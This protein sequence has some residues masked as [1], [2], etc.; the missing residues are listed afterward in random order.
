MVTDGRHDLDFDW[1]IVG[2]GFGGSIAA[3][4]L[5][6]RG[7]SVCV[8]ECG[9]RFADDELPES[10]WQLKDYFWSPRL[11]MRGILRMTLFRDVAIISG[12]GVGGGSLVYAQTLYRGTDGFREH[13]DAAVGEPVD[14]DRYYDVAERML[15]V[16]E[17]PLTTSRDH[18]LKQAAERIGYDFHPTRVGVYR[19]EPG[20]TVPDPYFGG[21]GPDRAG[22]IDCG[23]CIVSCVRRTR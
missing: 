6:E 23:R 2:S 8:L 10:A 11:G 15:G 7:Y 1:V 14:L 17:Q 18:M 3:L 12:A 4:R 13:L 16:V 5:V 21:E 9:R 19:G 20:K 22:C